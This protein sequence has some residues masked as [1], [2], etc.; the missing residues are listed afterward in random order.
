MKS[1]VL[2]FKIKKGTNLV[3]VFFGYKVYFADGN[4]VNEYTFSKWYKFPEGAIL[5]N[6]VGLSKEQI[7]LEE[8]QVVQPQEKEGTVDELSS[9]TK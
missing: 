6:I 8:M 4:S 1:Y 5:K 2:G 3:K 7:L 9:T